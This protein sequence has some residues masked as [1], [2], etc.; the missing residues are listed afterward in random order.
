[1]GHKEAVRIGRHLRY[2][3]RVNDRT[4]EELAEMLDV[5]VGWVSRIERGIKLPNLPFLF[6]VG[7]VLHVPVSELL[8]PERKTAKSKRYS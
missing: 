6:R 1:M 5:S 3:R 4:Q 7:K 2:V 8:P